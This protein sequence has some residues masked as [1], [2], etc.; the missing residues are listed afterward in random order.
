MFA[1]V[2]AVPL[3]IATPIFQLVRTAREVE[4]NEHDSYYIPD[5]VLEGLNFLKERTKPDEVVFATWE[6]SRLIPA[7]SGNTVLRGHWAVSV[8]AE[9]RKRW[10]ARLFNATSE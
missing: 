2:V 3:L 7:Y 5:D 8:D 4:I 9:N 10:Y 6:T 1:I